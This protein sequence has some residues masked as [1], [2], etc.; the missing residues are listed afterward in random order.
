MSITDK[1]LQEIEAN[2]I[3]CPI[4]DFSILG[5][6]FLL[7]NKPE[8]HLDLCE[9]SPYAPD[10]DVPLIFIQ[11]AYFEIMFYNKWL[12]KKIYKKRYGWDLDI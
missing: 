10:G 2:P 4:F 1:I 7:W 5:V 9:T 6:S 12:Y 11:L 8:T 3:V